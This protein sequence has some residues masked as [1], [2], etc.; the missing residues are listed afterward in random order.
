MANPNTRLHAVLAAGESG[1]DMVVKT[2]VFLSN[3]DDY[4]AMNEVYAEFF[5]NSKPARA[6]VQAPRLPK[7]ALV[8]IECIALRRK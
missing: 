8:E 1:L 6:C 3:F 5:T 4:A 2:T 7:D